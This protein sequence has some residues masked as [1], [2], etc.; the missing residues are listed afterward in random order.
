MQKLYLQTIF[1]FINRFGIYY[2]LKTLLSLVRLLRKSKKI[3][4]HLLVNIPNIRFAV[5]LAGMSSFYHLISE[6]YTGKYRYFLAG[7]L[8]SLWM[9]VDKDRKQTGNIS[10]II[11]IR[12]LYFMIRA[13]VYEKPA[14]E[15]KQ[16][17]TLEHSHKLT[18]K[19][20][21]N[22]LISKMRKY[23]DE[24]GDYT[25]WMIGAFH[26]CYCAFVYPEYLTKPY[27]SSLVYI[28]GGYSRYG[29][30]ALYLIEKLS[31]L[32][33][34]SSI[35]PSEIPLN[36]TKLSKDYIQDLVSTFKAKGYT[37]HLEALEGISSSCSSA[38]HERLFC[39]MQHP[40]QS[41]C[42][43]A[44]FE[45]GADVYQKLIK[46]Y[47]LINTTTFLF[48]LF[49][50]I[51]KKKPHKKLHMF[52]HSMVTAM[53]SCLFIAAYIGLF[54]HSICLLR[55]L[56]GKESPLISVEVLV[57]LPTFGVLTHLLQVYPYS[58]NGFI[59]PLLRWFYD[60]RK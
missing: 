55:R 1:K 33:R 48:K 13:F 31:K 40:T 19:K 37:E 5:S 52:I 9:I 56:Y 28:T 7:G 46:T 51:K 29:D 24:N 38:K 35:N 58:A 8:S 16:D 3:D 57:M 53:R 6:M 60:I 4:A 11:F 50:N 20:S 36:T 2:G 41:S 49:N 21:S 39:A 59:V 25:I 34:F 12:T 15:V 17:E 47:L 30:N 45:R 14:Q 18:V 10:Q 27:L 42:I 32:I 22:Q 44:G 54:S 23:I 43:L 26:I